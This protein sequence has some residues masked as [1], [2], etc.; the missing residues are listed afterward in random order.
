MK[1]TDKELSH[2][3]IGKGLYKMLTEEDQAVVAFGMI[4]LEV[5]ECAV[6]HY[7]RRLAELTCQ[8]YEIEL[9]PDVVQHFAECVRPDIITSFEKDVTL[10]MFE[11]ATNAGK[12]IA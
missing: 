6:K 9:D 7:K 11:A 2:K 4:P 5:M 10:G 1:D 3:E 12:M 8:K